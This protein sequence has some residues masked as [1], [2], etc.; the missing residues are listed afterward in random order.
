MGKHQNALR[1]A[2]NRKLPAK[3]AECIKN[4]AD[5][6]CTWTN[7]YIENETPLMLASDSGLAEMVDLLLKSGADVRLKTI[8]ISNG[9][10]DLTAL[11]YA[12]NPG[13]KEKRYLNIIKALLEA[14]ADPDS[15]SNNGNTPLANAAQ[16]GW[17]D[18]VVLLLKNGAKAHT[19]SGVKY[20]PLHA[21]VLSGN[22]DLVKLLVERGSPVDCRDERGNT[23]LMTALENGRED[24]VEFLLRH[25]ADPK[26]VNNLNQTTLMCAALFARD[27][28]DHEHKKAVGLL[29]LVLEKGVAINSKD[30]DGKTAL[31]HINGSYEPDAPNLLKKKGAKPGKQVK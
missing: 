20:P 29:K 4:G 26:A 17:T 15:P 8:S 18:A 10:G 19:R 16:G 22:T 5:V 21:A 27:A 6:N 30:N 31:D 13:K 14:G 1:Q 11:H 28:E 3:V 7:G 24:S 12:L 25:G 9:A 23:A 2:I